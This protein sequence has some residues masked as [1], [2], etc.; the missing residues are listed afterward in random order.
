MS[1]THADDRF[2]MSELIAL[3]SVVELASAGAC[4]CSIAE[5][6]DHSAIGRNV[7]RRALREAADA[8]LIV[9]EPSARL[10]LRSAKLT[11]SIKVVSTSWPAWFREAA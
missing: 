4:T 1:A 2:T 11:L 3:R 5:I 6:A 9:V 8:G 10:E 7:V